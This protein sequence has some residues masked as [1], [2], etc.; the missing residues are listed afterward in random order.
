VVHKP[1]SGFNPPGFFSVAAHGNPTSIRDQR[2][3]KP[4]H[5]GGYPASK[6][7]RVTPQQ[8]ANMLRG[9]SS[10]WDG[11]K[12]IFLVACSTGKGGNSFAQRLANELGVHVYAPTENAEVGSHGNTDGR[13]TGSVVVFN[14][15]YYQWFSPQK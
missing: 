13:H 12:P 9:P 4:E 5:D 10:G 2:N 3:Q 7:I 11:A 1:S 15:G 14:G 6:G 8:L